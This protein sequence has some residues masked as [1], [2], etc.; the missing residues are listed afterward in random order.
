MVMVPKRPHSIAA[1]RQVV[2]LKRR[3]LSNWLTDKME[4]SGAWLSLGAVACIGFW[5]AYLLIS[6]ATRT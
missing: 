2:G 6:S 3:R 4:R 5:F 1:R